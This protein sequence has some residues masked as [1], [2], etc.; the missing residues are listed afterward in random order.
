VW[1]YASPV[2]YG[3]ELVPEKWRALFSLNP[4]VGVIEASRAAL[5]GG[6]AAV[7]P[8]LL[9]PAVAAVAV[10]ATGALF[11]RRVERSFVDNL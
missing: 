6:G 10:L 7:L 8:L 9:V 11:F 4:L 2:V 5:L 1:M 3:L